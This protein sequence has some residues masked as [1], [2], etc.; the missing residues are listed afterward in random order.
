MRVMSFALTERQLMD[1][2]KDVTRRG[3]WRWLVEAC[4]RGER[5]RLIAVRKSMGLR[6]GESVHK[7]AEIEVIDARVEQLSEVT[8]EEATREGFP[9]WTGAEFV[10]FFCKKM[11][12]G[13]EVELTRIHF[14]VIAWIDHEARD[15][16]VAESRRRGVAGAQLSLGVP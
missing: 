5:P 9:E 4:A 13:P 8:D 10:R 15:R 12:V 7:L 3:G 14:R 11:G 1:G 16:A 2:T 6:K